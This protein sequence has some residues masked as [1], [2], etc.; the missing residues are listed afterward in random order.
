M[1]CNSESTN[2]ANWNLREMVRVQNSKTTNYRQIHISVIF[3]I[4]HHVTATSNK[5]TKR[6]LWK[7]YRPYGYAT[8]DL[9]DVIEGQ[10]NHPGGDI[11]IQMSNW[12]RTRGIGWRYPVK[13]RGILRLMLSYPEW[14]SVVGS[15]PVHNR[16]PIHVR[17]GS[18]RR[19]NWSLAT[20]SW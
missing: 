11:P 10:W 8:F 18:A 2:R 1:R 17:A 19:P 13:G 16:R 7:N 12:K 5:R 14:Y 15:L 20:A 4:F 9:Q 6:N 3:V